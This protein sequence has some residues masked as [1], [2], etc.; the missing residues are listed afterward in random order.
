MTFVEPATQS[1]EDLASG[2]ADLAFAPEKTIRRMPVRIESPAR[3]PISSAELFA[4]QRHFDRFINQL[5]P[6]RK[7]KI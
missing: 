6:P 2:A 3:A 4:L 7:G 5:N 1:F